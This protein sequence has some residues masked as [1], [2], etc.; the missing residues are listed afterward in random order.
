MAPVVSDSNYLPSLEQCLSWRH[1]STALSD[2]SGRRQTSPSVASFLADEYVHT[3]LK[4][5]ATA[6]APPDEATSKD[7]EAK[8]AVVNVSAALTDTCDA[9]TIKKDAQWLSTNAKVNLVAAL[10]IAVIEIQSRASRHLMGPL[11]SQDITNL[12]EA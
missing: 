8:T 7:F 1:V 3:L 2:D 6:F 9:E 5:P 12:Q 4:A 11:S 10:R